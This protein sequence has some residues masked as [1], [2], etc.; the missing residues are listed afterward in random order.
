L[1]LPLN[2]DGAMLTPRIASPHFIAPGA[3]IIGDVT[4][5]T[6]VSVFFGAVLRGDIESIS[7]GS[8]TNIQEHAMLHTTRG[9]SPCIVGD[10]VTV[11]HRAIVHGAT[12][13][14]NCLI[15]MG[16]IVLD[17]SVISENSLVGAGAL[18]TEG[19]SF[20]ARSLILGSPAKAVRQLNTSEVDSIKK[21]ADAYIVHGKQLADSIITQG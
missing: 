16:A 4:I 9:R 17:D 6:E 15:G 10:G 21:A 13:E 2:K 20:P 11:G 1:I 8:G 7:V 5:G 3:Y 12:I 14:K 19:K 18:V